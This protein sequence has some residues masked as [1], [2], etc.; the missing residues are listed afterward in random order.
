MISLCKAMVLG[1]VLVVLAL[2]MAGQTKPKKGPPLPE[3][4]LN[5]TYVYVEAYDGN[6]YDPRL[7]PEDRKAIADVADAVRTWGRYHL[8]LRREEAEIVIQVRKGRIASATGRVGGSIGTVPDGVQIPPSSRT[9]TSTNVGMGVEAGP[10]NDLLSVYGLDPKGNLLGPYW[11][12]SKKG[13]LN[14][15]SMELVKKFKEEVEATA[16]AAQAK[17]KAASSASAPANSNGTNS[18]TPAGTTQ[19][20]P[21]HPNHP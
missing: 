2:P 12:K 16:A 18:G 3:L 14:S 9:E 13:G 7:L 17:K 11:R 15:P 1:G 20:P 19:N 6:E 4:F 21:P 5:A 8:T 10:P